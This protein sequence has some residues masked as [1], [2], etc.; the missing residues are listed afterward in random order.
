[1]MAPLC[2][3]RSKRGN[4]MNKV[5]LILYSFLSM[6]AALVAWFLYFLGDHVAKFS[7]AWDSGADHYHNK[8]T[9]RV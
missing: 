4:N 5:K 3:K 1:M 8:V 7:E 6:A 9:E 2:F